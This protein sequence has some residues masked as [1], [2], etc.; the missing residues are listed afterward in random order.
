MAFLLVGNLLLKERY[1]S[2][3]IPFS[4][5]PPVSLVAMFFIQ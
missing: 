5:L 1:R 4:L 3:V 2:K